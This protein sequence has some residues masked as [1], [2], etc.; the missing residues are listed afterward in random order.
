MGRRS[1]TAVLAAARHFS[2][3]ATPVVAELR[4]TTQRALEG[5]V[6][7]SNIAYSQAVREQVG[8]A[9]DAVRRFQ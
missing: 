4:V 8:V 6:G 2:G 1:L 7:E 3:A 5:I 9:V